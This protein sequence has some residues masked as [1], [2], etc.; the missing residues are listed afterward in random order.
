MP[1]KSEP[2][3]IPEKEKK[4][5]IGT[6]SVYSSSGDS[7]VF[8]ELKAPFAPDEQHELGSFFNGPSPTFTNSGDN[9]NELFEL[10]SQIAAIELNAEQF[11][12]FVDSVCC[13][14][15]EIKEEEEETEVSEDKK[16]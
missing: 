9:V 12:S 11:D 16:K 7:F 15:D 5:I 13:Q 8:V 2:I 10:S 3:S 14:P 6:S 4:E 1:P